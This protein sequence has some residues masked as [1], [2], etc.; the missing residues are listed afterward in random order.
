MSSPR[1][2][3]RAPVVGSVAGLMVAAAI[4]GPSALA[5]G[6][7]APQPNTAAKTAPADGSDCGAASA[8]TAVKKPGGTSDGPGPGPFLA[9]IAQLQQAGTI[10][11]AQAR[12]LDNDIRAGS[13]DASKLVADGTLSSSQM[14]A[15]MERLGA[16]KRSLAPAVPT[17]PGHQTP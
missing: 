7:G 6:G 1:R 14:Q 13:I 16:V 17:K 4:V 2:R 12:I 11:S 8:G 5:S 3:W 9:A 10:N 15:V